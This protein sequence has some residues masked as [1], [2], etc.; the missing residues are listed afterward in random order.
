MADAVREWPWGRRLGWGDMPAP[1]LEIQMRA[2][3]DELAAIAQ[4]VGVEAVRSAAADLSLRRWLDGVELTGRLRA[5][6][7]RTCGV[8]LDPLDETIEEDL[9]LRLV[10]A[11]SS[12]AARDAA[13]EVLVSLDEP[14]PPEEI[15]GASIDLADLLTQ[16]IALCMSPFPRK[17]G[18]VFTAPTHGTDDSPFAALASLKAR[19]E[20]P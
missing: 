17:P 14:D 11:G 5:V 3:G 19:R 4:A 12:S 7:A 9:N 15:E 8:S 10:P 18:A 1:G 2:Q 16:Q 6:L 13:G 20:D